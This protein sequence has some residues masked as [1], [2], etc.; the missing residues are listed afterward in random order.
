MGSLKLSFTSHNQNIRNSL[1]LKP[2][3]DL[4]F[5]YDKE[6]LLS[7]QKCSRRW[8]SPLQLAFAKYM[9]NLPPKDILPDVW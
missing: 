1:Y 3:R 2:S 4:E 9:L 6:M 7:S 5:I 8:E